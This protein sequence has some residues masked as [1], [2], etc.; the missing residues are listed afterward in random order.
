MRR[1]IIYLFNNKN[2]FIFSELKEAEEAKTLCLLS[3]PGALGAADLLAFAAACQEDISH[4]RV[5]RDG[6]PD[7]YMALLTLVL[8]YIYIF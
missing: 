2:N 4:V 8:K 1:L 5:L 6:S 7:H 3:V